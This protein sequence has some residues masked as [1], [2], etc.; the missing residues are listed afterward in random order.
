MGAKKK[1]DYMR[2]GRLMFD[3][4]NRNRIRNRRSERARQM[5]YTDLWA[6]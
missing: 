2:S 3:K 6:L 1:G 4:G 5:L